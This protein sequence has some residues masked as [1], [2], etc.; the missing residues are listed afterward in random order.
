VVNKVCYDL[1]LFATG[2][3]HIF[4]NVKRDLF[5]PGHLLC[6]EERG[7]HKENIIIGIRS[8]RK[9][10]WVRSPTSCN[11]NNRNEKSCKNNQANNESFRARLSCC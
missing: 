5:P 11:F 10:A 2:F 4:D 1:L 6:F 8:T 9:I 3:G 7:K